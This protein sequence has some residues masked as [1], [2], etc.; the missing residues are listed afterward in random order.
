MKIKIEVDC[1]PQ[2]MREFFGLPD[3]QGLQADLLEDIQ[4]K[5]SGGVEGYDPMTLIKP[6]LPAHLQNLEN[7]QK[8]FWGAAS[9]RTKE[10]K[11]EQE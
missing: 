3:V 8:M 11:D 4:K 10:S 6:F 7:L 9:V 1:T 5:W 2:E